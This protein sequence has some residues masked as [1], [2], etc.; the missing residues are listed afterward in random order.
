MARFFIACFS[1]SVALLKS[2]F[3]MPQYTHIYYNILL[4]SCWVNNCD[5]CDYQWCCTQYLDDGQ[6]PF[7]TISDVFFVDAFS[8][9]YSVT[10][11]NDVGCSE[12]NVVEIYNVDEI[13]GSIVVD[14]LYT[15]CGV[16]FLAH[17]TLN[18]A[19]DSDLLN[20]YFTVSDDGE[21]YQIGTLFSDPGVF[22]EHTY[23]TSSEYFRCVDKF[24]VGRIAMGELPLHG[25]IEI[26]G[27]CALT[28]S[29][30]YQRTADLCGPI[31]VYCP[32]VFSPVTSP[33]VNDLWYPSFYGVRK[34]SLKIWTVDSDLLHE[35]TLE[36]DPDDL[37]GL[38]GEEFAWDGQTF[39]DLADL[40]GGGFSNSTFYVV[41][42]GL[43]IENCV[44]SY[45]HPQINV[46]CLDCNHDCEVGFFPNQTI[47]CGDLTFVQ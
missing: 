15:E 24:V 28:A 16:K 3:S 8:K 45:P 22:T 29:Y 6:I 34:A 42:Y 27:N 18:Q 30:N 25:N 35:V 19:M 32:N 33:G 21:G 20:V 40:E 1:A 37:D 5:N 7:P 14:E 23:V 11:T 38:S 13:F 17:I 9:D 47:V 41:I 10:V 4:Y 31:N 44:Y 12:E 43:T 36:A 26:I 39:L 46:Y 2:N